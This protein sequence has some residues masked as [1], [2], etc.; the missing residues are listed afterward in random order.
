M[1][2]NNDDNEYTLE[3]WLSKILNAEFVIT[4]SFHC[5]M[6]CLK[7][8]RRFVVITELE[9]NVEM[10]DRL[11]TLLTRLDL[12]QKILHK[13]KLKD[14]ERVVC[15]PINWDSVDRSLSEYRE[16]GTAFLDSIC[17]QDE[18]SSN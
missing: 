1:L 17:F 9:G 3:G 10:N 8:H 4:D 16:L 7:L 18:N 5:V 13:S 2:W 15:D 14:I 12:T 11:Y 6:M